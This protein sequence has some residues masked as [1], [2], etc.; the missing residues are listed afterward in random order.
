MRRMS[1]VLAL[2]LAVGTA[3][4]AQAFDRASVEAGGE[5]LRAAPQKAEKA[6]AKGQPAKPQQARSERPSQPK[7][8]GQSKQQGEKRAKAQQ[9]KRQQAKAQSGNAVRGKAAQAQKAA[10][11]GKGKSRA[12]RDLSA[13][14]LRARV[15]E[16]PPEMRAYATSKR[17]S[18]RFV[19]GAAARGL[20]YGMAPGTFV[21][22][23]FDDRVRVTNPRGELLLELEDERAR[24][25]G[26]WNVRPVEDRANGNGPA[27]CRSGEGHPVW[28]REWCVEKGFGLGGSR[29]LVWGRTRVDDVLFGRT[30]RERLDRG[31]LIDVLGDVVFS[32]LALHALSLGFH[33]PLAGAW[34]AQPDS[35]SILRI[36]AGDVVVAEFVD[37]DRNDRPEVMFVGLR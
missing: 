30:D 4:A 9:P 20:A 8:Q 27:F 16:L 33:E 7:A 24:N 37:L 10:A 13:S 12:R 19:A 29:D 17:Q 25:L 28:G 36:G 26:V 14:E 23:S 11:A 34:V 32:R 31:G 3:T 35:T 1:M 15:R 6:Q 5:A 22:R 18:Q 2:A 21:V